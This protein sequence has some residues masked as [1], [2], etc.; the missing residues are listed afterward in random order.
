MDPIES[1]WDRLPLDLA[2]ELFKQQTRLHFG[3][4][5]QQL[6]DGPSG[7]RASVIR[8]IMKKSNKWYKLF[9]KEEES[10]ES[11][12]DFVHG[13]IQAMSDLNYDY[14]P[15][16]KALFARASFDELYNVTYKKFDANIVNW[17]WCE[18]AG[19]CVNEN[20]PLAE[21]PCRGS[22][23]HIAS[24]G[25]YTTAMLEDIR[26]HMDKGYDCDYLTDDEDR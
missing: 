23:C 3:D 9:V 25:F 24:S 16:L 10:Y 7:E 11:F 8:S 1:H 20:V 6:G 22:T 26:Y 18:R 13:E 5:L 4:C 12:T 14:E 15:F 17:F 19:H 21:R 2:E